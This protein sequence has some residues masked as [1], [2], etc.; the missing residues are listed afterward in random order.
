MGNLLETILG[1][2]ACQLRI[3][4]CAG[5]LLL[6]ACQGGRPSDLGVTAARLAPCPASPNCVSSEQGHGK[7][8]VA[9]FVLAVSPGRAWPTV[10]QA[11][12]ELP[13]AR[14]VE[15]TDTYL[16]AECRSRVFGF[17]D[18][19]ELY[20]R[21]DAGVVSVR[22]ASRIG[23]WDLGANLRRVETLRRRLELEQVVR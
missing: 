3:V 22:S 12:R 17:V 1:S 21:A 6:A 9:P 19:L 23:Y 15:Q 2:T 10:V 7:R 4:L 13:G 11:A 18:D 5:A 20:L 14:V 8:S 16:H